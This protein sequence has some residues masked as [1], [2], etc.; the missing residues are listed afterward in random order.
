MSITQCSSYSRIFSTL[1]TTQSSP[2]FMDS[3]KL[4]IVALDYH[5]FMSDNT[6]PRNIRFE[7]ILRSIGFVL[8]LGGSNLQKLFFKLLSPSC[9]FLSHT[10]QT[11][12]GLV[13]EELREHKGACDETFSTSV[14]GV[15][16]SLHLYGPCP[17]GGRDEKGA[18]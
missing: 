1:T 13:E 11:R 8:L 16:F 6:P 15:W 4:C 7:P 10:M 9:T 2:S 14:C 5:F 12:A 17:R 18:A 3:T